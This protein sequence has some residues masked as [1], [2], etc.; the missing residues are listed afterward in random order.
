[1][2]PTQRDLRTVLAVQALRAFAYGFASVVL[3]TSLAD[4]GLTGS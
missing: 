2:D 1:M 3:G 4:G